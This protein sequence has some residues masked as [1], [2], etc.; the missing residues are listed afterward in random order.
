M[1]NDFISAVTEWVVQIPLF[2]V[3]VGGLVL[4][5]RSR[6]DRPR[7][8][9][10]YA[11]GVSALLGAHAAVFIAFWVFDLYGWLNARGVGH[12]VTGVAVSVVSALFGT[13]AAVLITGAVFRGEPQRR[14]AAPGGE[15]PEMN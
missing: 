7:A 15:I 14:P 1:S 6:R 12:E 5:Y 9:G 11:A 3:G 8:A 10:L 13:V 2:A 4:A